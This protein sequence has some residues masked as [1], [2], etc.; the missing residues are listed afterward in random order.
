LEAVLK[1]ILFKGVEFTVE[2]NPESA[3]D[4]FINALKDLPVTRLSIGVQSLNDNVLKLLGRIHSAE[5]A[6]ALIG[7]LRKFSVEVNADIIYDIPGVEYE[8]VSETLIQ[9]MEFSLEHISAYS[10]SPDTGYLTASAKDDP[11]EFLAVEKF[12]EEKGYLHYEVSNYAQPGFHSKHNIKYWEEREYIGI[13]AGA[14]SMIIENGSVYRYSHKPDIENYIKDPIKRDDCEL[15]DNMTVLKEALVFGLR[16]RNGI[17]LLEITERY[18]KLPEEILVKLDFL[19]KK[20][21]LKCH[22]GK[23]AAT[24]KGFL[25]LDSVTSYLW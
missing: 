14:H 19:E 22:G 25:L 17:D 10:Y 8:K 23:V 9:L 24:K 13:G 11:S 7:K 6:I 12:L 20:E 18:G 15:L 16:L 3:K 21:M 4:D 1:L 2:V 5:D